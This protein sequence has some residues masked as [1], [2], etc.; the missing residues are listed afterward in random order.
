MPHLSEIIRR[1]AYWFLDFAT[2]KK[3]KRHYNEIKT[4]LLDT[5][6]EQVREVRRKNLNALLVHATKT[7]PFYKGYANFLELQDFP[8]I[9]KNLITDQYDTFNLVK[10]E[11]P[12][13]MGQLVAGQQGFPLPFIKT[14]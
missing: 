3:V 8:I 6:L 14:R 7:T 5:N 11:I 12:N 13:S 1:K 2:G 10:K 4:I 9:D